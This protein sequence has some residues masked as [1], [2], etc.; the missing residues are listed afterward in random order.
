MLRCGYGMEEQCDYHEYSVTY[1]FRDARPIQAMLEEWNRA[2][3]LIPLNS[4]EQEGVF[5]ALILE[6]SPMITA[7]PGA[8]E[9]GPLAAYLIIAKGLVRLWGRVKERFERTAPSS[10]RRPAA[11]C[12]R[13]D[14]QRAGP[15]SLMS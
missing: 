3:R 14:R 5:S 1:Q 13:A 6:S 10:S 2:R 4:G 11:A 15:P 9:G 7:T 12:R 8:N